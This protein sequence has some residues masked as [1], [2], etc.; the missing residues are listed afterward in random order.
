LATLL[1]RVAELGPGYDSVRL[2][3]VFKEAA[4][5]GE[6]IR[7]FAPSF[8]G[9]ELYLDEERAFYGALGN[10]IISLSTWNP[11]KIWKGLQEINEVTQLL[12]TR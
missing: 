2:V 3:G 11:F 7:G 10:E 6:D 4:Y 8:P 5:D 12:A 1:P 9:A